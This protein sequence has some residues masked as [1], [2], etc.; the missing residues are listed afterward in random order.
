MQIS[1]FG[2]MVIHLLFGVGVSLAFAIPVWR[3]NRKRY[4]FHFGGDNPISLGSKDYW[5]TWY[6]VALIIE[7]ITSFMTHSLYVEL[8]LSIFQAVA[9]TV[10][11]FAVDRIFMMIEP[12]ELYP[13]RTDIVVRPTVVETRTQTPS[14]VVESAPKP[15]QQALPAPT[16]REA[17]IMTKAKNLVGK[18][19]RAPR[20]AVD[21]IS[22][23]LR[24]QSAERKERQ[25]AREAAEQENTRAAKEERSNRLSD[26]T[27]RF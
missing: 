11:T 27:G 17:W 19:A 15:V 9:F 2:Q 4:I 3:N 5:G 22:Q 10:G 26:L 8:A 23:S 20:A 13:H 12:T 25:A 16:P 7:L 1:F 24:G 18:A 6:F 14:P 21:T